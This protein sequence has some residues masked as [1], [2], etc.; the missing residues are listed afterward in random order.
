[1]EDDDASSPLKLNM[2]MSS[3]ELKVALVAHAR[4]RDGSALPTEVAEK[5]VVET[6][7]KQ[8]LRSVLEGTFDDVV[9]DDDYDKP[10]K[11]AVKLLVYS[12]SHKHDNLARE[13]ARKSEVEMLKTATAA[14][15]RAAA[16]AS[17][18]SSAAS[19]D[20]ERGRA[21]QLHGPLSFEDR[22]RGK[23]SSYADRMA[24]F[25]T[26]APASA[27]LSETVMIGRAIP[28]DESLA[29]AINDLRATRELKVDLPLH[30]KSPLELVAKF[31]TSGGEPGTFASINSPNDVVITLDLRE[32]QLSSAPKFQCIAQLTEWV[33]P[34]SWGRSAPMLGVFG[35]DTT[36][37]EVV[38]TMPCSLYSASFE[39]SDN[40]RFTCIEFN[41][42]PSVD[43]ATWEL[44]N[45]ELAA[46]AFVSIGHADTH[47]SSQFTD[48]RGNNPRISAVK[49]MNATREVARFPELPSGLE[50]HRSM[51]VVSKS[52]FA[53]LIVVGLRLADVGFVDKMRLSG[54]Y[55]QMA[56]R[57]QHVGFLQLGHE[58]VSPDDDDGEDAGT[59]ADDELPRPTQVKFDEAA[60]EQLKL[61]LPSLDCIHFDLPCVVPSPS[62]GECFVSWLA[63]W[64]VIVPTDLTIHFDHPWL[65]RRGSDGDKQIGRRCPWGSGCFL[66]GWRSRNQCHS[67]L[68][69]R[70]R[71]ARLQRR[72]PFRR[73][74]TAERSRC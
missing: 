72:G 18:S 14:C 61:L 23:P 21:P 64:L 42:H 43:S 70:Q 44:R 66:S 10:A 32:Q 38:K 16:A 15:E 65:H 48:V 56:M 63:V 41:T 1:M 5:L 25:T 22:P 67:T 73:S 59:M 49:R 30:A 7:A 12:E 51:A 40:G 60:V 28:A 29:P 33:T 13:A 55:N 46:A 69:S 26:S 9:D 11:K 36:A 24:R 68:R 62:G 58:L 27:L 35:F 37:G 3:D 34:P 39:S 31:E 52:S 57:D 74:V 54:L 8:L 19:A 6:T 50:L 47:Y 45:H 71:D 53:V 4:L 20:A 17:S 2:K